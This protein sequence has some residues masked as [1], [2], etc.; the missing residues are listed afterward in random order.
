MGAVEEKLLEQFVRD[1]VPIPDKIQNAPQL[2]IGLE[3]YYVA[4]QELNSCRAL[5]MTIGPIPWTAVKTYCDEHGIV[6][7]LRED[8]FYYITQMD[9]AYLSYV[10]KT[11][12]D[13]NSKSNRESALRG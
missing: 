2:N 1:G 11:S 12:D 7:D 3:L 5:G 6:S 4:F 8:V 13:K 9:E 10:S